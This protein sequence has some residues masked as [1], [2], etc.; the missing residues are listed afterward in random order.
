MR[1]I[2]TIQIGRTGNNIGNSFWNDICSEHAIDYQTGKAASGTKGDTGVFFNEGKDGR[3]VPRTVLCDLNV[4]DLEQAVRQTSIYRPEATVATDEG[5]GNCYAKAF[6]TEGPDVADKVLDLVRKEIEKCSCLQGVQFFH[7]LGGGTG[8]GLGGLL[9]KTVSDYLDKGTGPARPIIQSVATL[10]SPGYSDIV[11]E[12]YNATLGIQDVLEYCDQVFVHDNTALTR[13]CR[14]V[15]NVGKPK[16]SEINDLI[17]CS[18]SGITSSLRFPGILNADLRKLHTNL[19]PFKNAHFLTSSFA[20]LT[21]AED[22]AYRAFNAY[23]LCQQMLDR[24]NVTL[25]CDPLD[26]GSRTMASFA[27]FRGK[28]SS[29]EVDDILWDLEKHGSHFD[30]IFPDWIPCSISSSICATASP[31]RGNSVTYVANTTAIH[32]V[33]DRIGADFDKMFDARSHI[34]RY[35]ENGLS[36]T[37]MLEARNVVKYLGDQ[38]RDY[39]G[40]EDKLLENKL[41]PDGFRK[42]NEKAVGNEEQAQILDE[43]RKLQNIY[44]SAPGRA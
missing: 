13:I 21:A 10:P 26:P 43:L 16:F 39:A 14:E 8:S 12:V 34:H 1:E 33:F 5:S 38:Y 29:S 20:P 2:V 44:I 42:V 6:H 37:D 36:N 23:D 35:E 25:S 4:Q 7:A 18:L 3:H 24:E 15:L 28:F 9:L 11:L 27:A 22:D 17:A 30:R 32:E 41:G 31:E 40:W 19:V